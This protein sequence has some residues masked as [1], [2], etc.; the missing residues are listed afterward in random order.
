MLHVYVNTFEALRCVIRVLR[1]PLLPGASALHGCDDALRAFVHAVH[2]GAG[3][4]CVG[5]CMDTIDA[6]VRDCKRKLGVAWAC[7]GHVGV[8]SHFL[9]WGGFSWVTFGTLV[10]DNCIGGEGQLG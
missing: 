1:M 10:F 6:C 3:T 9:V 2:R 7:Q 5:C 4:A 8:G